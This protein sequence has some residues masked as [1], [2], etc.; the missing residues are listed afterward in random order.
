MQQIKEAGKN[1]VENPNQ[2]LAQEYEVPA[3]P[4]P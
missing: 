1:P 2:I 4:N 3:P